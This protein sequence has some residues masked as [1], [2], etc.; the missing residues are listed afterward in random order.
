M[1]IKR[2]T[3][4]LLAV[5]LVISLTACGEKEPEM[6]DEEKIA[7]VATQLKGTSWF[8]QSTLRKNTS[9]IYTYTIT[10]SDDLEF[11]LY[12]ES[13][14]HGETEVKCDEK[15]SSISVDVDVTGHNFSVDAKISTWTG[16][17]RIMC[18]EDLNIRSVAFSAKSFGGTSIT[19]DGDL[20]KL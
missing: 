6:T 10:F 11:H 16:Y 18:D 14:L 12:M 8:G 3:A 13:W 1:K 2:F 9:A 15:C 19:G 5:L 4:L 20:E 7:Y 17:L